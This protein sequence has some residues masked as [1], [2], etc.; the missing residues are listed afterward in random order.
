MA[1]RRIRIG[2]L[3]DIHQYDDA[4]HSTAA[5]FDDQPISI[6]QSTDPT[7]AI[8]Q[9]QVPTAGNIVSADASIGDNK[10]VRGDGGA[11]KVQ[12][13]GVTIDDSDN[14]TIPGTLKIQTIKSGATQAAA[15]AA[16]DELW[17][18]SGH[19]SLPDNVVMIGV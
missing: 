14:I 9:D 12:D 3:E 16:A 15:G 4:D 2:S 19:A 1:L 13:S 5:D 11:K 7:Q 6:G 8:R 10:V 17:K 18:T